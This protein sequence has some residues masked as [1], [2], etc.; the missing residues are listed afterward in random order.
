MTRT[1]R[2]YEQRNRQM[3]H[4]RLFNHVNQTGHT[5]SSILR[6]TVNRLGSQYAISTHGGLGR[7]NLL[8]SIGRGGPGHQQN[9]L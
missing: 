7:S 8:R 9:L 1:R 2:E 3:M 6:N 5:L 4:E